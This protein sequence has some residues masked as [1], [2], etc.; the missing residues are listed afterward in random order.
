MNQIKI[1]LSKY[2]GKKKKKKIY[3]LSLDEENVVAYRKY[4]KLPLSTAINNFLN[5][6]T[7]ELKTKNEQR[8]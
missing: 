6:L 3:S 2:L 4:T 5:E 8:K 7:K 1:D